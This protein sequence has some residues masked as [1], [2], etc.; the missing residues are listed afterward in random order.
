M[1]DV[2]R[3]APAACQREAIGIPEVKPPRGSKSI[4]LHA[5]DALEMRGAAVGRHMWF[6]S[7]ELS[8]GST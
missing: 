2:K 7:S 4:Q 5:H 8:G 3:C 6:K 1:A